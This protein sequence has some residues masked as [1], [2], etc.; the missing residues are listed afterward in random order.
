MK[1]GSERNIRK[2]NLA[3]SEH[4]RRIL[5]NKQ[6]MRHGSRKD[7]SGMYHGTEKENRREILLKS[8]QW[9]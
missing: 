1:Q 7:L 3:V 2:R 5:R 6:W 8:L 9:W 4:Q